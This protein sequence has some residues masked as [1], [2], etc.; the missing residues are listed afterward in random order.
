MVIICGRIKDIQEDSIPI[1][2]LTS[3][4]STE[5]VSFLFILN[6]VL[7]LFLKKKSM[8]NTKKCIYGILEKNLHKFPI[9][10]DL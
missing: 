9:L 5:E 8:K 10:K 3:M 2:S 7:K 1:Y 6:N 4:Y